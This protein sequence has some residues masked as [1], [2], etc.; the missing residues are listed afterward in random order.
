MTLENRIASAE[1]THPNIFTKDSG[2]AQKVKMHEF[3]LSRQIF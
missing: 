2:R 3:F 1:K